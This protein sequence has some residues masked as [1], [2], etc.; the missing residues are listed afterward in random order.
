MAIDRI[1]QRVMADQDVL[2]HG[3][4]EHVQGVLD[5]DLE[6][7]G[8][9]VVGEMYPTDRLEH[10]RSIVTRYMATWND[11]RTKFSR[12]P[13]TRIALDELR[14]LVDDVEARLDARGL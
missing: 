3:C 10:G 13:E 5:V 2:M 7:W 9:W 4:E 11:A 14:Q 8:R 12:S 6:A 1:L